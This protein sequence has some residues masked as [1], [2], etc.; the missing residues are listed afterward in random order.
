LARGEPTFLNLC[1]RYSDFWGVQGADAHQLLRVARAVASEFPSVAWWDCVDDVLL[2]TFQAF[3]PGMAAFAT[4][5]ERN[6]RERLKR[7]AARAAEDARE[8]REALAVYAVIMRHTRKDERAEAYARW[9]NY[10]FEQAV[11][12]LDW[13]T[14]EYL[15]LRLDGTPVKAIAK[16]LGVTEKTLWNKY[17]NWDREGNQKLAERVRREVRRLVLELPD[18]HRRLLVRHLRDEAGLS[19]ADVERLLGH[20]LGL[21]APADRSRVLEEEDLL[22]LLGWDKSVAFRA[23][24]PGGFEKTGSISRRGTESRVAM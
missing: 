24:R 2:H 13:Q 18:K 8:E 4:L 12:R 3:Q 9:S 16:H 1:T 22:E 17:G 14:R 5:F 15:R 23:R 11:A 20:A 10:L 19:A 7:D 21:F 6:L